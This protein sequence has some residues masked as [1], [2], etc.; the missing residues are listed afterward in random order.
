[1]PCGDLEGRDG[2]GKEVQDGGDICV[3]IADSLVVQRK[4]SATR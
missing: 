3:Q 4:L 2:V 1:M